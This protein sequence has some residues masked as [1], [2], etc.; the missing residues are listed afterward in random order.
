MLSTK[1]KLVDIEV[2]SRC[3]RKCWFCPNSYKER[4]FDFLGNN[5][6]ERLLQD[7]KDYKGIIT[8]ARYHE[9]LVNGI[10][11]YRRIKQAKEMTKAKL[12]INTNGDYL[13]ETS[14]DMLN[15]C[16]LDVINLQLYD[17]YQQPFAERFDYGVKFDLYKS[18]PG[19][20]EWRGKY[21]NIEIRMYWR[22]FKMNG[23]NRGD[24]KLSNRIRTSPCT[25][26]FNVFIDY[27]GDV[28]PC[29]NMRGDINP[30]YVMGNINK[31]S[32]IDIM[33]SKKV[34]DFQKEMMTFEVKKGVCRTCQF[35]LFRNNIINKMLIKKR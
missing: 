17:G 6:Y 10:I 18:V 2:H 14:L 29:C 16:G 32:I 7:M 27:T 26:P 12:Y 11:L 23:V 20:V 33:K 35:G 5:A 21:K 8:F 30:E 13:N 34:K 3:N 9:P 25:Q 22:D 4:E 31:D 1:L 28:L 24:I 15:D 19:W